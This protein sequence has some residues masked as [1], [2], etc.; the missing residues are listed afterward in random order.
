MI[1]VSSEW[2]GGF[3]GTKWVG[4]EDAK[5]RVRLNG[6]CV[7]CTTDDTPKVTGE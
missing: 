4:T 7:G 5:D 1:S 3:V 6:S 2:H